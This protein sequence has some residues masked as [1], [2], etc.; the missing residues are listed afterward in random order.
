[1]K[2]FS[3]SQIRA[4]DAHTIQYEPVSSIDL[5]ER[6]AKACAEWIA[7]RTDNKKV[8]NVFCGPGNNGGDGLAIARLLRQNG[9]DINT[10]IIRSGK[11]YSK[12][13][14]EN[15]KRLLELNQSHVHDINQGDEIPE[16][17]KEE[18]VIDALFGTGLSK[19]VTGLYAKVI[20]KI[21][22]SGA[23]IISID[24]PAGL[25]ADQHSGSNEIIRASHTLSFQLP[26]LACMFPENE[27]YVG[28]FHVLDIRLFQP[29]ID[30]QVSVNHFVTA[31][32]IKAF[33]KP[34]LKFSHKG[35]YGHA[36]I[37]AGSKAKTGA[38]I[39]A[40]QACLRSGV[41][42]VSV[43]IPEERLTAMQ[44]SCPEAMI[45]DDIVSETYS[46]IGIG[47]GIGTDSSAKI[48][49][50]RILQS[51]KVPV[52]LDAD[53]LNI[54]SENEELVGLIPNKSILT[55]HVKEFERLAGKTSNDFE[56]HELQVSFS[57]KYQVFMVL[58]GAHSCITTPEGNSYF[59]ST[60]NPGMAK[61]GSGDVL[62]GII[63]GLLAQGY[64]SEE[65]A[66]LGVYMHGLAGDL[67][68]EKKGMD[69]MI[70]GDIV[71]GISDAWKTL[72]G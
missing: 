20:E 40:T 42:L 66:L 6:A 71:N 53:A 18:Y 67:A 30:E 37:V 51:V 43:H 34:R 26:K 36:L 8:F 59:N 70:A 7:K 31:D 45:A 38:A 22:S 47:P 21:N 49:L 32:S 50:M 44:V 63:T 14:L 33:L 64:S 41:G 61:G 69:G 11:N 62:T 10:F 12:D 60:G 54:I 27:K 35:N 3:A 46:A 2:I 48:M 4:T 24:M 9:F 15:E 13:F 5:M 58:K 1:M 25:F 29:F 55:P 56:R 39:L 23:E 28:Q 52:V 19:P 72:R 68:A 65:S 17:S 16:F 57:K